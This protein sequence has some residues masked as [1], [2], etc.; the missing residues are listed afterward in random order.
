MM[1]DCSSEVQR[2]VTM[3]KHLVTLTELTVA[4][5]LPLPYTQL[6]PCNWPW[7]NAHLA[8]ARELIIYLAM[9]DPLTQ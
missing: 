9:M 6:K 4:M 5:N 8:L 1:L 3:S 7:R 2:G